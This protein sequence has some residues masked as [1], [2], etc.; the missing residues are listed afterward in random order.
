MV[1]ILNPKLCT[2]SAFI[3]AATEFSK[4]V[5]AIDTPT[6]TVMLAIPPECSQ[7]DMGQAVC[8]L[9]LTRNLRDFTREYKV[10]AGVPTWVLVT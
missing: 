3:D 2:C 10:T 7:P 8:Y 1:R 6:S 4:T 9:I 5:V